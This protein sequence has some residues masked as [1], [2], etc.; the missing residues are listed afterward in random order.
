MPLGAAIYIVMPARFAKL[1]QT[2]IL[3]GRK[4]GVLFGDNEF[5]RVRSY[6]TFDGD[7]LVPAYA[8]ISATGVHSNNYI[9][10]V[11]AYWRRLTSL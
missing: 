5:A 4:Q 7:A 1:I 9:C 3:F 2:R 11:V 6:I 10:D 8:E